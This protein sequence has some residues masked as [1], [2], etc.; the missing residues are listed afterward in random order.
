M[1]VEGDQNHAP[2]IGVPGLL[3]AFSPW[4]DLIY[5]MPSWRVLDGRGGL[6]MAMLESLGSL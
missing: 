5:R 3:R 1:V 4:G 6:N 2:T